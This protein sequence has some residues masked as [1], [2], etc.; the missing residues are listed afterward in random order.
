MGLD[1]RTPQG[2]G[3]AS[4]QVAAALRAAIDAGELGEGDRLPSER[5]LATAHS[6]ARNTA[7]EAIR[8]LAEAGLVTAEHGRGVFVRRKPR[9][10]R[11]GQLRYSK[12]LRNATGL[13]PFHAEVLAQNRVPNAFLASIERIVPP[14]HIAERLGV[15]AKTKSVVRRE[16]WYF[17]D[18]EPIQIGLT[19]IPWEIARGSV[20]A[21]NDELGPGDLYARFEDRG[22]LMTY[23][24]EEV[25][26]RMPTPEEVTGLRV[27]DGVPVLVVLHTGLDQNRRP[28][29]VTEFTIRAD[30]T[31]LDYTMP[32]DQ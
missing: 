2:A 29:E 17:V 26:A 25:T 31:G 9:L 22:H 30:H 15:N 23:T 27:P 28:F 7:R 14:A 19:Y 20:L 10:M 6:V 8:Q 4:R 3:T 21:H 18:A 13:S 16:N 12:K 24:R 1:N 32:V 11:F 5:Q